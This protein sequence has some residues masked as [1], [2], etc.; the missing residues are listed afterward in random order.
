MTEEIPEKVRTAAEEVVTQLRRIIRATDL[1]A[2]QL[3]RESGLTP[4]QFMILRAISEMG[5]VAISRI[6][7]EVNLTQATVTTIID[8]LEDKNIVTRR[9]SDTDKRI[10]HAFLTED[11]RTTLENAPTLLQ[12]EFLARFENLEK[13]EQTMIVA[14]LQRVSK[15]MEVESLDAS[16]FLDIGEIDRTPDGK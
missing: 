14:A 3:A 7:R 13:W 16:P 4:P 1:R 9:R 5:D 2:K 6:A 11:G 10:V 15:L 12:S 8:K